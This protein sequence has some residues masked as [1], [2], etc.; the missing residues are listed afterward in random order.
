MYAEELATDIQNPLARMMTKAV[1]AL[2]TLLR[3]AGTVFLAG[4]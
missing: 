3:R 1:F 2:R 4:R